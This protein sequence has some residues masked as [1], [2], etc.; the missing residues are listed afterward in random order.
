MTFLRVCSLPSVKLTQLFLT[1]LSSPG[2][3]YMVGDF[4]SARA[5]GQKILSEIGS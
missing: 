5:K 2:A 4:E 1:D 3:F